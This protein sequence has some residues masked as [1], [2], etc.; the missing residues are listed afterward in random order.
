MQCEEAHPS[1]GVDRVLVWVVARLGD[2]IRNVMDCDDAV[3][4]H[5]NHKEENS[6]SEVVQERV[7]HLSLLWP[8]I[9]SSTT[10]LTLYRVECGLLD[11][12]QLSKRHVRDLLTSLRLLGGGDFFPS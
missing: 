6:E 9:A 4:Q 3:E 11:A 5:H 12:A 10:K 1:C 8:K 7:T 2:Q